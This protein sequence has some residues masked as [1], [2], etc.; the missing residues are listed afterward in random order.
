MSEKIGKRRLYKLACNMFKDI[1]F[2]ECKFVEYF[3]CSHGHNEVLAFSNIIITRN[4][5]SGIFVVRHCKVSKG[6]IC[7]SAGIV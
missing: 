3:Y 2:P 4:V 7:E 1:V 6:D 5:G